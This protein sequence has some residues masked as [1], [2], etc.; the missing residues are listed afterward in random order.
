MTKRE[1]V[2][3]ANCNSVNDA[4]AKKLADISRSLFKIN[5]H[6]CANEKIATLIACY[7]LM[8]ISVYPCALSRMLFLV[9]CDLLLKMVLFMVKKLCIAYTKKK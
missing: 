8:N 6:A 9:K 2:L 7:R 3:V 4:R 1:T 5:V